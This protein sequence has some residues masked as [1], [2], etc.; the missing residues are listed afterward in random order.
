MIPL[1]SQILDG[2]RGHRLRLTFSTLDVS[3]HSLQS[4]LIQNLVWRAK[5]QGA[6]E[7]VTQEVHWQRHGGEPDKHIY[8]YVYTLNLVN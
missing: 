8:I 6:G 5:A 4:Q 1:W 3:S 2:V 7:E